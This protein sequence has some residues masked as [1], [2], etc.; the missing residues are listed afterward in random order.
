MSLHKHLW[1]A[2]ILLMCIA[3]GGCFFITTLSAQSYLEKQLQL[4][5]IDHANALAFFMSRHIYDPVKLDEIINA[6][7]DTGHYRSI[8]VS[9][10]SGEVLVERTGNQASLAT[11][12]WFTRLFTINS[13]PATATIEGNP[14]STASLVLQSD[15]RPAYDEMWR[16]TQLLF[17]YFLSAAVVGG[18]I[19][20][21]FLKSLLKPLHNAVI[22][23]EAIG[24]RRFVTIDLPYTREFYLLAK[25]L[26]RL[27]KRVKAMLHDEAARLDELHKDIQVD[28][29]TG[30]LTRDPFLSRLEST[31]KN[32]DVASAG[33]LVILRIQHMTELNRTEGR[34]VINT[35]LTRFSQLLTGMT[36]RFEQTFSGRLNGSDLALVVPGHEQPGELAN[37]INQVFLW[38]AKDMQLEGKIVIPTAAGLYFAGDTTQGLLKRIDKSLLHA[39]LEG[40]S[41]IVT[42]EDISPGLPVLIDEW[43]Q[44][45]AQAINQRR[46]KLASYPVATK[47]GKVLH[48][49][50]PARLVQENGELLTAGQFLPWLNRLNWTARLDLMVLELA[51]E[52]LKKDSKHEICISLSAQMLDDRDMMSQVIDRIKK[53]PEGAKRLWLEITE[54]GVFQ[55]LENF[56]HFC[57]QL[58]TVG[59][60]LGIE[61]FGPGVLIIGELHDVG[62]D[63]VKIDSALIRNVDS[64]NSTQVFLRGLCAIIHA[65]GLYAIA[66]G[67]ENQEEWDAARKMGIDAGTGRFFI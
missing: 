10:S 21:R 17:L 66:E 42:A 18:I 35:L 34:D 1:L 6:R 4:K 16:S 45:L 65:I 31:I 33:V 67:I 39:E 26:N 14:H 23:A 3:F 9:A 19:G 43:H 28:E 59:C 53:D 57:R 64:N 63:Y 36:H 37:E 60:R 5:N 38:I 12:E 27:S 58:R 54:Y 13:E 41:A 52:K 40:N 15:T 62:I 2:I 32:D 61:H 51:F 24:Q 46:F 30:L 56:K 22:Q 47:N 8:K 25:S 49:E 7:F 20:N 48:H 29:V 50:C 11:P 44:N 55:H